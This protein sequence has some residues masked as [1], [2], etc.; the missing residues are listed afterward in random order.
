MNAPP[1]PSARRAS[2]RSKP[3]LPLPS[4]SARRV[5]TDSTNPFRRAVPTLPTSARLLSALQAPTPRHSPPTR[6]PNASRARLDFS[7]RL[8]RDEVLIAPLTN[9]ARQ[10]STGRKPVPPPRSLTA[11]H[12][13]PDSSKPSR[14]AKRTQRTATRRTAAPLTRRAHRGNI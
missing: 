11:P 8:C 10:A 9:C 4:P 1:T 7:T 2:T 3:V 14:R 6:S 13:R 12:A 5:R